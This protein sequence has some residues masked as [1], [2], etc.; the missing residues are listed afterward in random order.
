MIVLLRLASVVK[1]RWT[2]D[3]FR[4]FGARRNVLWRMASDCLRPYCR[5]L[6]DAML[7]LCGE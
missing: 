6:S 4:F 3:E 2:D 7:D 5:K 1:A